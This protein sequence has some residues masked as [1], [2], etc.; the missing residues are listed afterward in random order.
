MPAGQAFL[1]F[2]DH[3]TAGLKVTYRDPTCGTQSGSQ[4]EPSMPSLKKED[5]TTALR[6]SD[7]NMKFTK[8]S[9]GESLFLMVR[10][11]RGYWRGGDSG[12]EGRQNHEVAAP[13]PR[14]PP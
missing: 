13:P 5:V 8:Y 3:D 9:A 6:K 2:L 7:G 10:N 14:S 4:P 12:G 11:G 1:K